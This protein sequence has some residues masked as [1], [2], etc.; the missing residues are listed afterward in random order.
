MV[1]LFHNMII[2][3]FP[4]EK[5]LAVD[6]NLITDLEVICLTINKINSVISILVLGSHY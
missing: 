1:H 3:V 6:M 2:G 5:H 4:Y